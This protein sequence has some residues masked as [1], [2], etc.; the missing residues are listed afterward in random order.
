MGF[1][2][3]PLLKPANV[4]G[5]ASETATDSGKRFGVSPELRYG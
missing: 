2:A 3:S 4:L 1:L 5:Q